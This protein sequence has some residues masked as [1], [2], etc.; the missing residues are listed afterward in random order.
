MSHGAAPAGTMQ[1]LSSHALNK[2]RRDVLDLLCRGL[3]NAE[4]GQQLGIGSR[5]VKWYVSQLLVMYEA[6][7]RTELVGIVLSGHGAQ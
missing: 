6:T 1:H 4:I 3:T 2:R 7:N 5:T